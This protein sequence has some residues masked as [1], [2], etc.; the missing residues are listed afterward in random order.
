MKCIG[1]YPFTVGNPMHSIQ[2]R[3]V[4]RCLNKRLLAPPRR[5][6]TL[7]PSFW[8]GVGKSHVPGRRPVTV[9]ATALCRVDPQRT[10]EVIIGISDRMITWNEE[11][12]F[13]TVNQTKIRAFA[14]AKAVVLTSG[15]STNGFSAYLETH[16]VVLETG[17]TNVGEIAKLY[18]QNLVSLTKKRAERLYLAPLGL[19]S[20][21]FIKHQQE[22]QPD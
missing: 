22:M 5:R 6:D 16:K 21:S 18:A 13:E 2:R 1:K 4:N 11:L 15:S 8:S 3:V 20:K 10:Q 12:E 7:I 17:I 9:C 19:T 14:P